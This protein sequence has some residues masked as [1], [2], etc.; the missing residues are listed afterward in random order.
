MTWSPGRS[1]AIVAQAEPLQARRSQ[2]ERQRLQA[3]LDELKQAAAANR[4]ETEQLRYAADAVQR[5][6]GRWEPTQQQALDRREVE[7][8]GVADR[9]Q[10][11]AANWPTRP[12]A[13]LR[14]LARPARQIAE[15]EAESSR[16]MLDQARRAADAT[17][18]LNDLRQ[19]DHRLAAVVGR[20]DELQREFD[21]LARRDAD[22]QPAPGL[23]R[24]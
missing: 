7:A 5:G 24:P 4:R 13:A 22:S 21:A 12:S 23:G 1:L 2:A 20:L 8:H 6:N 17:A 15:V 18:R 10:L 19:A 11:L 14:R 3:K 9:L 16:A